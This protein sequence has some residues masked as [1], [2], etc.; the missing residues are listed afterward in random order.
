MPPAADIFI[1]GLMLRNSFTRTFNSSGLALSSCTTSTP[2]LAICTASPALSA[3]TIT[4]DSLARAYKSGTVFRNSSRPPIKAI[5]CLKTRMVSDSPKRCGSAPPAMM[6]LMTICFVPGKDFRVVTT[7]ISG[8]RDRAAL[9]ILAVRVAMPEAYSRR[10]SAAFHP[11]CSAAAV[12]S[13]SKNSEPEGMSVP[14]GS[15]RIVVAPSL[16]RSLEA[17]S[18]QQRTDSSRVE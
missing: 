2:A 5:C 10:F 18:E 4:L 17:S 15:I 11:E 13:A 12:P 16:F 1:S 3:S 9:T 7:E 8:F 6:A 14:L